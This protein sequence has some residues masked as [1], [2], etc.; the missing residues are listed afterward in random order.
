M[1]VVAVAWVTSLTYSVVAA[2]GVSSPVRDVVRMWCTAS[3][4]AWKKCTAAASES[5]PCHATSS[6]IPVVAV[7]QSLA[8]A[9]SARWASCLN[10]MQS[11]CQSFTAVQRLMS[12]ALLQERAFM[13][14]L[15]FV[16]S[17][18]GNF[19][20]SSEVKDCTVLMFAWCHSSSGKRGSVLMLLMLLPL[21]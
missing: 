10:N 9:T 6:V 16:L 19:S 8:S 18:S 7:G 4:S 5:C 11:P 12:A 20:L 1:G 14:S 2:A 17:A 15:C 21:L 3:K 13:M